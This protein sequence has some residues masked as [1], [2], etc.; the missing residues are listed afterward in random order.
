MISTLEKLSDALGNPEARDGDDLVD[1]AVEAFKQRQVLW[2]DSK[3]DTARIEALEA[4]LN[5]ANV[6]FQR[7]TRLN[8][9]LLDCGDGL[10]NSLEISMDI[11][12]DLLEYIDQVLDMNHTLREGLKIIATVAS[13]GDINRGLRCGTVCRLVDNLLAGYYDD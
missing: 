5:F 6:A 12:T 7:V 3:I 11:Q 8:Q 9:E 2:A 1:L 10:K 13:S 4:N